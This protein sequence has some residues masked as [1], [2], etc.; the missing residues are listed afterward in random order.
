MKDLTPHCYR[1]CSKVLSQVKEHAEQ[2]LRTHL[3]R[4]H[5]I[6]NTG[7]PGGPWGDPGDVHWGPWGRPLV[8]QGGT[9]GTSIGKS[10]TFC[11][12]A[13]GT[14]GTFGEL[15]KSDARSSRKCPWA[16]DL[17]NL[18]MPSE[19]RRFAKPA[20][21][22]KPLLRNCARSARMSPRAVPSPRAV[23]IRH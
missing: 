13:G 12:G 17:E 22:E 23:L 3:R 4:R 1:N 18:A 15:H 19:R 7:D 16:V 20:E 14:S 9:L 10:V 2:R 21:E 8:N 5:K 6:K 11:S